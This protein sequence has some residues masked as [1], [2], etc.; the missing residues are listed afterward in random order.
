MIIQELCGDIRTTTHKHV[1]FALN[2]EGFNNS[3]FAAQI[4][5]D[6]FQEILKTE[7]KEF[8]DYITKTI[9]GINYWGIVCYS[10]KKNGWDNSPKAILETLNKLPFNEENVSILAIGSSIS[11]LSQG[12]PWNKIHK[13][14]EMCNINLTIW[15]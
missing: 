12:A 14:L 6:G 9:D 13:A 7:K 3:G 2:K 5:K 4:A 1:V 10:K 11:E 8:G 15:H